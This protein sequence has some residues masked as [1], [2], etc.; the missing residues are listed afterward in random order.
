MILS[1]K[2]GWSIQRRFWDQPMPIGLI[3]PYATN[4]QDVLT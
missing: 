1:N 3:L 4:L 2:D